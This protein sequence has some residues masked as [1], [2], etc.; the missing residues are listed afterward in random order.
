MHSKILE[1]ENIGVTNRLEWH[2]ARDKRKKNNI[3][4]STAVNAMH[5]G[6]IFAELLPLAIQTEMHVN[7]SAMAFL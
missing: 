7:L 6:K 3:A 5:S 1:R 2:L 4:I